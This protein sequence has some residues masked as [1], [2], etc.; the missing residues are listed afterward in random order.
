MCLLELSTETE[1]SPQE[2]SR[3]QLEAVQ[4]LLVNLGH[5]DSYTLYCTVSPAVTAPVPSLSWRW[6]V[7]DILVVS[8]V[9]FH[10]TWWVMIYSCHISHREKNINIHPAPTGKV[11]S[12]STALRHKVNPCYYVQPCR[13]DDFYARGGR[14]NI[15]VCVFVAFWLGELLELSYPT[16]AYLVAPAPDFLYFVGK[17]NMCVYFSALI[18]QWASLRPVSPLMW[19]RGTSKALSLWLELLRKTRPRICRLAVAMD[20]GN[21]SKAST[22]A[23]NSLRNFTLLFLS[24]SGF[25]IQYLQAET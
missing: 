6:L 11:C 17:D 20:L 15:S 1:W 2:K 9:F 21:P 25:Y 7:S 12:C 19:D 23:K 14:L 16:P 18:R 4:G 10:V 22:Y 24:C 3:A 13:A 8:K 5:Y